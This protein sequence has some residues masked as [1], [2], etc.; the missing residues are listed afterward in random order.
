MDFFA[1]L[2][3]GTNGDFTEVND[4]APVPVFGDIDG[5]FDVDINDAIALARNFGGPAT[6][7]YDLNN[8]GKVGFADYA[9]LLTKFGN[10][11]GTPAPD[12]YV[13]SSP[14]LSCDHGIVIDGQAI[15]DLNVTVASNG[16]CD[17][18]IRNSLLVSGSFALQTNGSVTLTVDNSI[19]VGETSWI[20][21]NGAVKLSAANSV[22]HGA[23]QAKI[24][25]TDRGGN[26]FE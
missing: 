9:I 4:G 17:I 25:L 12:P 20:S 6:T 26:V 22:F 21:G 19:I 3:A 15:Q 7:T 2:S 18:T 8:D 1:A 24:K 13:T 16:H 11:S 10:G 5:D 14:V 23:A